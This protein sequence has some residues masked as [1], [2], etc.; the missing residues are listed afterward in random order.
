MK[1][2]H[3]FY[4]FGVGYHV[5]HITHKVPRNSVSIQLAFLMTVN[6]SSAGANF[7]GSLSRRRAIRYVASI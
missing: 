7:F 6:I 1:I 4:V 2:F 3:F 5:S